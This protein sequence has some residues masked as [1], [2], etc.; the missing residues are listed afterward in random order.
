MTRRRLKLKQS[1]LGTIIRQ[2]VTR[3]NHKGEK[4][5][6]SSAIE[7]TFYKV[8]QNNVLEVISK[9][10]EA[11]RG[12][13]NNILDENR[14]FIPTNRYSEC[15]EADNNEWLMRVMT[16]KFLYWKQYS[17][18]GVVGTTPNIEGLK[19]YSVYFQNSTDQDYEY[20][21]WPPFKFFK[22][23][24]RDV[25]SMTSADVL[26]E[27]D[28]GDDDELPDDGY[29]RRTAVYKRIYDTL[30]L[31][32]VLDDIEGP[33]IKIATNPLDTQYRQI[34]AFNKLKTFC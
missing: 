8:G 14:I 9:I 7:V 10:T 5:I 31:E 18:L 11:F 2:R 27:L 13:I 23:T 19:G 1:I 26:K 12:D 28:W 21:G 20:A 3:A 22:D 17:L 30:G 4:N 24:I 32:C 15:K 6:M 29:Y 25:K 16:R 34:R 33:Y